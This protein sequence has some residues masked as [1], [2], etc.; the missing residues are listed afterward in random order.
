MK[1]QKFEKEP[2]IIGAIFIT[3]GIVSYGIQV[4]D[5]IRRNNFEKKQFSFCESTMSSHIESYN[6]PKYKEKKIE[7][8]KL[9][10]DR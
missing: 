10:L 5:A 2:F 8:C 1:N 9:I 4:S 3:A 6:Y 7:Y